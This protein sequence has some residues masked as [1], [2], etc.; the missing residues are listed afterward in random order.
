MKSFIKKL[1]IRKTPLKENLDRSFSYLNKKRI[2]SKINLKK[3]M[4]IKRPIKFHTIQSMDKIN[5]S[6][7]IKNEKKKISKFMDIKKKNIKKYH[8]KK[9]I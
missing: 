6:K 4:I 5:C 9:R 8:N 3:N 2:N 7:N 1:K